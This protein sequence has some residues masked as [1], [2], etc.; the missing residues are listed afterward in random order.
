MQLIFIIM[1]TGARSFQNAYF[2]RGTGPVLFYQF[3][4]T[5]REQALLNCFHREV[6]VT[7][8]YCGHN[9]DA[10]VRCLGWFIW[11]ELKTIMKCNFL[12]HQLASFIPDNCT[13]GSVHLFGS[14]ARNGTVQVCVNRTWGS[15][16]DRSWNSR[17]ATVICR[18][19][20]FNTIGNISSDW[21]YCCMCR[22][23]F[24][25]LLSQ[26][27]IPRH[28]SYYGRITGPVWFDNLRCTGTES[29]ILNCTL[30]G[31]GV[32]ASYCDHGHDAGVDCSGEWIDMI[33]DAHNHYL[34]GSSTTQ[35]VPVTDTNCTTGSLRLVGGSTSQEGRVEVCFN[36]Q[37]GTVCDDSWGSTDAGVACR[38]LGFSL[39]G[40]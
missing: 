8:Y 25:L 21:M 11:W 31:V 17:S 28:N 14:S 7:S 40:L 32:L 27:P 9:Y 39:Y 33:L 35:T 1:H 29:N 10:G 12:L 37:W 22:L 36:Y 34:I 3:G 23:N 20:G 6:G 2:G 16:C 15:I 24:P 4:C 13:E 5:G 26:G 18:Q 38:Q 19:L 30:N